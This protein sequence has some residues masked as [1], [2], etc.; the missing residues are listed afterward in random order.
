MIQNI[1]LTQRVGIT[2]SGVTE[3]PRSKPNDQCSSHTS[4][5]G[6]YNGWCTEDSST[7]LSTYHQAHPLPICY[8]LPLQEAIASLSCAWCDDKRI[9]RRE[10]E[11]GYALRMRGMC[12]H[13]RSGDPL[14]I[15][16]CHSLPNPLLHDI[17]V[18]NISV[19]IASTAGRSIFR[20]GCR[21][22]G[23]SIEIKLRSMTD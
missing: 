15:A 5:I 8:L 16:R 3:A 6:V 14:A 21:A 22:R 23:F 12:R 18:N 19:L 2:C 7:D 1:N 4:C 17:V 9:F 20:C 13:T 10:S 11:R